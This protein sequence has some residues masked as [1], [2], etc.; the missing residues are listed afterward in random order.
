M[1]FQTTITRDEIEITIAIEYAC[2]KGCCGHCDKYGAP[3]EPDD[4]D[5]IEI[6]KVTDVVADSEIELTDNECKDI[7]E[8]IWDELSKT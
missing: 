2:Y 8:K 7:E 4:P 3:E 1:T 6:E 5:S